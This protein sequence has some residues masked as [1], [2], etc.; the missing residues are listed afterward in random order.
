MIVDQLLFGD[1]PDPL[2]A[3]TS[4]GRPDRRR[5]ASSGGFGAGGLAVPYVAVEQGDQVLAEAGEPVPHVRRVDTGDLTLVVGMRPGDL[6]LSAPDAQVIRLVAPLLG[7]LVRSAELTDAVRE[8]R[9][10]ALAMIADERRRLRRELHDGLGPTLTGV[11]FSTDAARNLLPDDPAAAADLL[12]SV[13]SDT[14]DAID[15]VRELVYGMRPPALDELGLVRPP[16]P[17]ASPAPSASD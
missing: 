11:A 3:A 12:D 15:Q 4:R 6:R 13:R 1:R 14:V 8:S 10:Q 16:L 2:A 17:A 5:P 9:A 7:Q